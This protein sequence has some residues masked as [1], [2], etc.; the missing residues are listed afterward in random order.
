MP[1]LTGRPPVFNEVHGLSV[2]VLESIDWLCPRN[3]GSLLQPSIKLLDGLFKS[4]L[5]SSRFPCLQIACN[6]EVLAA[7]LHH[8]N[9]IF[10][11]DSAE[12]AGR[13]AGLKCRAWDVEKISLRLALNCLCVHRVLRWTCLAHRL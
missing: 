1:Q 8:W 9:A 11:N 12:M 5:A 10:L 13:I 7:D 4:G 3:L 6:D 2:L